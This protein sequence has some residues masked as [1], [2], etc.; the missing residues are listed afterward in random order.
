MGDERK[1]YV[2]IVLDQEVQPPAAVGSCLLDP[3]RFVVLL[4]VERGVAQVTQ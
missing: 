3:V 4:R 1:Q 2:C